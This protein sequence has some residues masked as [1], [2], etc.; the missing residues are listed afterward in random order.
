MSLNWSWDEF[1][2][3]S[4]AMLVAV[5]V[6]VAA[7]VVVVVDAVVI[8]LAV[9]VDEGAAGSEEL[10]IMGPGTGGVLRSVL[11]YKYQIIRNVKMT[12]L[13]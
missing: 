4:G 6:L 5:V 7:G 12:I 11:A 2:M 3:I 9:V 8:L 1:L 13:T 10:S